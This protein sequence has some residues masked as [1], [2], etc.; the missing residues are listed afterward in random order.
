MRVAHE[1]LQFRQSTHET[2]NPSAPT[3]TK[4]LKESSDFEANHGEV[5]LELD[6]TKRYDSNC[7]M[8]P[9]SLPIT[10]TSLTKP[11]KAWSVLTIRSTTPGL[12]QEKECCRFRLS[13]FTT[14]KSA[15]LFVLSCRT[16][17]AMYRRRRRSLNPSVNRTR[18]RVRSRKTEKIRYP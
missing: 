7:Y 17:R 4:M 13:L 6:A 5:F 18:M 10:W 16:S 3:T 1:Y 9:T 15:T 8:K 2:K 14:P 12:C 11:R